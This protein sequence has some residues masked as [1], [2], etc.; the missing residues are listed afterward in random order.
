MDDLTQLRLRIGMQDIFTVTPAPTE[1]IVLFITS[2]DTVTHDSE[3]YAITVI[4]RD[5]STPNRRGFTVRAPEG[6]YRPITLHKLFDAQSQNLR[7]F[8]HG[9]IYVGPKELTG[10][11]AVIAIANGVMDIEFPIAMALTHDGRV[12]GIELPIRFP[13]GR[14]VSYLWAPE[15]AETLDAIK[16]I[17]TAGPPCKKKGGKSKKYKRRSLRKRRRRTR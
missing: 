4:A 9:H 3:T 6:R 1:R 13:A 14:Q 11:N 5:I 7:P 12:A 2:E 15:N 8:C 10:D 17:W 16:C